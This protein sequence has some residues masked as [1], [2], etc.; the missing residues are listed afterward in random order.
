MS[1]AVVPHL[2]DPYITGNE[3]VVAAIA[4]TEACFSPTVCIDAPAKLNLFLEVLGKR[5]DGFH[6]IESLLVSVGLSDTLFLTPTQSE[7][8]SLE[9]RW[10]IGIGGVGKSKTGPVRHL[11]TLPSNSENT[12]F[13]ALT[14]L[15]QQA[16]TARGANVLV[17]KR[18]PTEAGLGGASSDA[19]SA[20]RA[21]N[22]CWG[23][24]WPTDRLAEVAAKVGSDVPF[25]L[26]GGAALCRGRGEKVEP[27]PRFPRMWVVIVRPPDGIST[28]EVYS[29]CRPTARPHCVDQI[30][31]ALQS[32]RPSQVGRALFNRL[33]E[34]AAAMS[35][36][37]ARLREEFDS[38]HLT[39]HAMTGSGSSYFGI[40]RSRGEAGRIAFRLRCRGLG[41]VCVA[42]FSGRAARP[43]YVVSHSQGALSWK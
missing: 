35:P 11:G 5:D 36:W 38:V 22:A 9:M 30:V 17:V 21:A 24:H 13:R 8:I 4:Q 15:Q 33:T 16:G 25:F 32:G 1:R 37:I 20:L 31:E 40:C 28:K 41:Q 19:A 39:G 34:P 18:I 6:E 14:L 12:V 23:L 26:T 29:R 3:R 27:L 43:A 42:E 7:E 10:A 2:N